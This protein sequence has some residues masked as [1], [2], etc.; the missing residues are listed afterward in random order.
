[1]P[2]FLE[3]EE[4]IGVEGNVTFWINGITI[5]KGWMFACGLKELVW[6][7]SSVI[8]CVLKLTWHVGR[9]RGKRN[10]C[11]EKNYYTI[12]KTIHKDWNVDCFVSKIEKPLYDEASVMWAHAYVALSIKTNIFLLI[13]HLSSNNNFG[14]CY[15]EIKYPMSRMFETYCMK[16]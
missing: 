11:K 6:T 5:T 8:V 16:K 7:S 12:V 14:T 2:R 3:L 15:L 10:W 4:G 1:M 13:K 9:W